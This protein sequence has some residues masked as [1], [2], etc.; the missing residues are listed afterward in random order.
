[1]NPIAFDRVALTTGSVFASD[2]VVA[3]RNDRGAAALTVT[4]VEADGRSVAA[5]RG[6]QL[7]APL[8]ASQQRLE[9]STRT[10]INRLVQSVRQDSVLAQ[11]Y[12][13]ETTRLGVAR[14]SSVEDFEIELAKLTGELESTQKKLKLEEI[15]QAREQNLQ[16]MEENQKKIKESTEAAAQAQKSGLLSKIFGWISAIASIIVGA[17]MIATGVGAAVGALMIAG[18][19]MGIVSQSVQ[20]AA[21]DGLISKEVMEKLGPALMGIEIAIA[22]IAAVASFG[23][24]A[25]GAVAKLGAKIGGKA[26]ELTASLASKVADVG[27]KFGNVASQSIS[28]G[29]KLGVQISDVTL[30]VANGVTQTTHSALQAKAADKQA[31]A[32]EARSELTQFQTVLDKLKEELSRMVESFLQVMEL[33]FQ[34]I[35]AKGDSLHNLSSRPAAI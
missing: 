35:N 25:V 17:I 9:A 12:I 6:V 18:G 14:L 5:S 32:L 11:R 21:K 23:G 28:H 15:K 24:A 2:P 30:D 29:A 31:D 33:I 27:S 4:R 34:M 10:D 13:A 7:T 19:V 8:A 22:V 16:K 26:A 1:M 20:Q 3:P